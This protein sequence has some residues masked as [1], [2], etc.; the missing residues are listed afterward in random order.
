MKKV[1]ITL[2]TLALSASVVAAPQAQSPTAAALSFYRALKE[3]HYV[4]GFRHSVYRG[5]VEGLSAAELQELEPDFART[6]AEIPDRITP[7]GEQV[8]GDTATVTLKFA[9]AEEPQSVALIHV[10]GEW[11][12]GDQAALAEV[13]QQGRAYFFNARIFANE[14]EAVNQLQHIIGHQ[15]LYAQHYQ[16]RYATLADL[17]RLGGVPKDIETGVING[18]RYAM[19]VSADK[20]SFTVSAVPV[21][22]GKSGRLSFYADI[23]GVRA[24]DLKGQPA[25][26]SAPLFQTK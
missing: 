13:K 3:K 16:G 23:N 5:A 19:T 4:E 9:D 18:Y 12:V 2:I 7:Q 6:F 17:I 14:D 22:Y 21:V 20:S 8:T 1:L 11:L 24:Q 15:Y 26:V 10:G 25:S